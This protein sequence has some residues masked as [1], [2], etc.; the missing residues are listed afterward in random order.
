MTRKTSFS[1]R[2][3]GTRQ[4]HRKPV[5]HLDDCTIQEISFPGRTGKEKRAEQEKPLDNHRYSQFK[6]D[7]GK[8]K[9]LCKRETTKTSRTGCDSP[10]IGDNKGKQLKLSKYLEQI[11]T[12]K[13]S[14]TGHTSCQKS[15]IVTID[16]KNCSKFTFRR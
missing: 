12:E 5:G 2:K 6:F 10:T 8:L 15:N 13:T 1:S 16:T 3:G 4:F 14:R 7:S 9:S 11:A